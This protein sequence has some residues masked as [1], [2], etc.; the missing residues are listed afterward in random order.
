MIRIQSGQF[1]FDQKALLDDVDWNINAGEFWFLLGPNGSGKTTLLHS[2]LGITCPTSGQIVRQPE[3]SGPTAMAYVPQRIEMQTML[4]TTVR[5]YVSLGLAGLDIDRVQA[6]SRI[7]EAITE[8]GLA[9][10]IDDNFEWLSGGQRQ[11]ALLAR[12]LVRRPVILILDEPTSM[13]DLPGEDAF[14]K[15]LQALRQR[16]NLTMILVTHDIPMAFRY[17]THIALIY[18]RKLHTGGREDMARSNLL[19]KTF[20]IPLHLHRESNGCISISMDHHT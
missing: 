9:S 8:A 20:G 10:V 6:G 15:T 11:R 13:L 18:D 14:L 2:L 16:H 17:A 19:Q 7:T 1:G 4:R 3:V 5:E 12:A